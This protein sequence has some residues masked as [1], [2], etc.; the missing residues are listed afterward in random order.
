M[1]KSKLTILLLTMTSPLMLVGSAFANEDSSSHH[2]GH[3]SSNGLR[4][5]QVE[6]PQVPT[7]VAP[8]VAI[9]S[10]QEVSALV[11]ADHA[12]SER[13]PDLR[14]H[15]DLDH[16]VHYHGLFTGYPNYVGSASNEVVVSR[17]QVSRFQIS[18]PPVRAHR[19]RWG[20]GLSASGQLESET[21]S[22]AGLLRLRGEWL[23]GEIEIG[24]R[25]GGAMYLKLSRQTIAPYLLAGAGKVVLRQGPSDIQGQYIEGGAGLSIALMPNLS[26][27]VDA[28]Y[29]L[30]NQRSSMTFGQ[31]AAPIKKGP[32][33]DMTPNEVEKAGNVNGRVS[34][35]W[36]F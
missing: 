2:A 20:G 36:F 22:I 26:L 19:G 30:N 28:R 13:G 8:G 35:V 31:V 10:T 23:E 5:G 24:K 7:S 6:I 14:N 18:Q 21:S 4:H 34:L 1:A 9:E 12:Q 27:G 25:L 33:T 15:N 16:S 17:V 29:T 32:R 11:P 3:H